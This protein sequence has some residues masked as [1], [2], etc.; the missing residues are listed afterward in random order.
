V[1]VLRLIDLAGSSDDGGGGVDDG[2]VVPRA[3]TLETRS[4]T[5]AVRDASVFSC[6]YSKTCF[7]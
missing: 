2:V 3:R 6:F 4:I 1:G 5:T 7:I